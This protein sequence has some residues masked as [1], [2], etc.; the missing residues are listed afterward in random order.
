[1]K[2]CAHIEMWQNAL[3]DFW[4]VDLCCSGIEFY[5]TMRVI[6][7]HTS[8]RNFAQ[9]LGECLNIPVIITYEPT[10]VVRY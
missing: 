10:R 9:A 6:S 1:M 2:E 8:A 7:D 3:N 4:E 5:H